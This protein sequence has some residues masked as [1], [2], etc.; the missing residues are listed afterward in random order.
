MKRTKL[1]EAA[2]EMADAYRAWVMANA[3]YNGLVA[4]NQGHAYD[5][6]IKWTTG[7]AG[8]RKTFKWRNP[9]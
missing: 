8:T 9:K 7:T 1:Q 5:Y 2:N 4:E 6:T 3:K